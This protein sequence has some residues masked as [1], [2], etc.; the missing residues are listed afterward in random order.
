MV[1]IG[2]RRLY[3]RVGSY[4]L[5]LRMFSHLRCTTYGIAKGRSLLKKFR[6]GGEFGTHDR[7]RG[8]KVVKSCSQ[9]GAS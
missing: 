8:S 2:G 7:C 3:H 4:G 1:G 6:I 5:P 9:K